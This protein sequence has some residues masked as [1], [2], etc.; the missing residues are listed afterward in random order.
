MALSDAAPSTQTE[1]LQDLVMLLKQVVCHTSQLQESV[2]LGWQTAYAAADAGP[3]M[4]QPL[5]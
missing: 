4:F 3:L 5:S 1:W 2:R